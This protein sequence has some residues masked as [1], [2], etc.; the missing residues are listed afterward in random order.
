VNATL[1]GE[2]NTDKMRLTKRN[3]SNPCFW[4]ALWNR[5]Y[6]DNIT[7]ES[8]EVL[9]ARKQTVY[10]LNVRADMIIERTVESVHVDKG[11]GIAKVT[12]AAMKKFCRKY[13]PGEYDSFIKY[14]ESHPETLLLPLEQLLDGWE[15]TPA[16]KT[17]LSVV[18]KESIDT[19]DDIAYLAAFVTLQHTR[20]HAVLRSTL[21]HINA[22]GMEAF[23]YFWL[24]K[25][26]M[27]NAES[28]F[29][30]IWPLAKSQWLLY[31]TTNHT[32]PLPDTPVLIRPKSVMVA[33]SPR[34][35][36]EIRLDR[37]VPNGS[38]TVKSGIPKRKLNEYRQRAIG[39]TF[40]ELILSDRNVLEEWQASKCFQ[41]Q[42]NLVRS[43]R[44]YSALLEHALQRS[45]YP[46]P[47]MLTRY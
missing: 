11:I 30:F 39:S 46:D 5:N 28:L 19:W 43:E 40:K 9:P 17:L 38:C 29:R 6:L 20:S 8:P 16:Y 31:R 7:S 32:F 4:T 21:E 23:E 41:R 14:M 47:A 18:A 44:S 12:P 36:A 13:S 45:L 22:A 3:H 37:C 26:T 33:L 34:L 27:S 1:A 2:N 35:L 25:H 15:K 42:V 24:L 10:S